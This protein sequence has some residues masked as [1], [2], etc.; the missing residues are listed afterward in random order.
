MHFKKS[1]VISLLHWTFQ[2]TEIFRKL[3][4]TKKKK[5]NKTLFNDPVIYYTSDI[6]SLE[7]YFW[8]NISNRT[9]TF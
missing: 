3:Y 8:K 4:I 2:F 9:Y 6:N 7:N 1:G 5:K